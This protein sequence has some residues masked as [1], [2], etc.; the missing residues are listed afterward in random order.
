MISILQIVLSDQNLTKKQIHRGA[1]YL[2]RM[3]TSTEDFVL[4]VTR[5]SSWSCLSR[6]CLIFGSQVRYAI[7]QK[8]WSDLATIVKESRIKI[9]T[10]ILETELGLFR[11][12]IALSLQDISHFTRDEARKIEIDMNLDRHIYWL[13]PLV[14]SIDG[15]NVLFS[16]NSMI[17]ILYTGDKKKILSKDQFDKCYNYFYYPVKCY[18]QYIKWSQ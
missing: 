3:M 7:R 8:L 13:Q 17:K 2:S 11:E 9:P 1:L 18:D 10:D 15:K 14:L 4:L 12:L 16:P 5:L 6:L